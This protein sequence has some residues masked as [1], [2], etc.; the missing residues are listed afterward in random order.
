MKFPI[1][2]L[3]PPNYT[4]DKIAKARNPILYECLAITNRELNN[5]EGLLLWNR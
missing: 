5:N 3:I 1:V 2:T 4:E